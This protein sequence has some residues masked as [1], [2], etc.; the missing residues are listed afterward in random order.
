MELVA[1]RVNRSRE[2][3]ALQCRVAHHVLGLLGALILKKLDVVEIP[4]MVVNW[5]GPVLKALVCAEGTTRGGNHG[6]VGT[7]DI[8]LVEGL[9]LLLPE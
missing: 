2:A 6:T 8:I 5:L 3:A 4:L 9:V 1:S 7:K